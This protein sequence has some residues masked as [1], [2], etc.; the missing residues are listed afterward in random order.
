MGNQQPGG[1]PESVSSA[2]HTGATGVIPDTFEDVGNRLEEEDLTQGELVALES[3]DIISFDDDDM[4]QDLAFYVPDREV[5]GV[6][7]D[8][9]G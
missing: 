9:S 7:E 6:G 5:Q 4:Q 8:G 1:V 2:S 3:V